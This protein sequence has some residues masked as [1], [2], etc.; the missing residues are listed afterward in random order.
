MDICKLRKRDPFGVLRHWILTLKDHATAFVYLC[1][2]PRK[3]ANLIACKLQEIFGIIGYPKIF[4]T[5]NGKDLV[6]AV[7]SVVC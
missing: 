1:A 6:I 5:D 4:H 7:L 3:Q 2:L